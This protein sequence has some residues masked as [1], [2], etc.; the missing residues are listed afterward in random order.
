[1]AK[2]EKVPCACCGVFHDA[3][4]CSQCQVAGCAAKKKGEKCRLQANYLTSM[5]MSEFQLRAAYA[6][7]LT[8]YAELLEE[9]Q[10]LARIVHAAD[11]NSVKNYLDVQAP[12]LDNGTGKISVT[13]RH[14]E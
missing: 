12:V 8:K 7:L 11:P 9:S 6:E 10:R 5:Q 13:E 14:V 2:K 3:S 1:M 4:I